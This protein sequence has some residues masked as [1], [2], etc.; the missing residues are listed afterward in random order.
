[1]ELQGGPVS[2]FDLLR[3]S[4]MGSLFITRPISLDYVKTTDELTSVTGNVFSMSMNGQ[5]N[6]PISRVYALED[7]SQA[8]RDLESRRTTG[9]LLL[10]AQEVQRTAVLFQKVAIVREGMT[11]LSNPGSRVNALIHSAYTGWPRRR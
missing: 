1:M 7:A 3:L 11:A 9:K 6:V 10:S 5:L 2:P 4:S 8:H